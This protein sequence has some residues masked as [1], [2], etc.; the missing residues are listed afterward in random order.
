MNKIYSYFFA[1]FIIGCSP[2][3]AVK[4]TD[5]NPIRVVK[6][7]DT[8]LEKP[9][10]KADTSRLEKYLFS[11]GLVNINDLDSSFKINLVYND[12]SNFLHFRIY[13]SLSKAL[14]PCD[15]AIKLCNAQ[16]YL[17]QINPKLSLLIYDATRPHSIQKLIWDSLK[18]E[19]NLKYN[20]VATPWDISL[21]NYGAAVDLS[22]MD[23]KTGKILDMG[24]SVDFFGKLAEP[25]Y[26]KQF[27]KTKQLSDTAYHNRLLLRKVMLT[28][29]FY[30]ISSEWWHFN[31]CNKDFAAQN[32]VLIK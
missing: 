10:T 18:M 24:T 5:A 32:Y 25:I 29:R 31:S 7:K 14:L 3:K 4:T 12:T 17:K 28:A 11:N 19:P 20:Y 21:H 1:I 16:F 27:L 26:E 23:T 9:V 6:N 22:I 30:P 8:L 15:V 13:D 2:E